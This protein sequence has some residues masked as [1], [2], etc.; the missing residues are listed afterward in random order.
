MLSSF[1]ND[2]ISSRNTVD[3][4]WNSR[5]CHRPAAKSEKKCVSGG[6]F[7]PCSSQASRCTRVVPDRAVPTTLEATAAVHE[8][9]FQTRQ[10]A[11]LAAL[12]A[13]AARTTR[14]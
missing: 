13:I 3:P 10:E 12:I 7:T 6:I 11:G 2:S 1:E 9:A 14:V 4:S 8:A 5:R